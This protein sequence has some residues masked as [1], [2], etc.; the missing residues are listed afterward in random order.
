MEANYVASKG[1]AKE[2]KNKRSAL[3][4]SRIVTL[5]IINI[6]IASS[7]IYFYAVFELL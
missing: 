5:I 1:E 3:S 4:S 2:N 7:H 6:I